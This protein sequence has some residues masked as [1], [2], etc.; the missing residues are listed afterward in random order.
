[1]TLAACGP[2]EQPPEPTP[3]EPNIGRP[4]ALTNA[5]A[6]ESASFEIEN[7]STLSLAWEISVANDASNPQTG[8]W[9]SVSPKSGTLASGEKDTIT[10]TLKSGL[11]AGDYTSTLTV[12]YPGGTTPFDVSG[13]VEGAAP[14]PTDPGPADPDPTGSFSLSTDPD[15]SQPP[16]LT[17]TPSSGGIATI[18][19]GRQDGFTG[20]VDLSLLGA[21]KGVSGEFSPQSVSGS[22]STLILE[23]GSDV[24]T[25]EYELTVKGSSSDLSASTKVLLSVINGANPETFSLALSPSNLSVAQGSSKTTELTVKRSGGFDDAVNLSVSGGKPSGVTVTVTPNPVNDT[26]SV[27]VAVGKNTS[28]GSYELTLEGKGG[29][30][31]TATKLG[32]TVLKTDAANGKITGT[33]TTDNFLGDFTVPSSFT[34]GG[35]LLAQSRPDYVEGQ[36]LIDYEPSALSALR[37]DGS[38]TDLGQD[39]AAQYGFELLQSSADDGPTLVRLPAGKSVLEA[40]AE[41]S[42]DSRVRHAGPNHYVYPLSVPNDALYE[43]Q[44]HMAAGGVPVAWDARDSAANINVAIIDSG[45]DLDHPDLQ[46]VSVKG[47]DFCGRVIEGICNYDANVSPDGSTDTHGTHNL[48]II[49]AKGNSRGVAGVLQGGAKIIPIKVFF[50]Y[51][52]TTEKALIDAVRWSVGLNVTGVPKNQNKAKII[53]LSLGINLGG[54]SPMLEKAIQQAQSAGA[55]VI[56]SAGN[57]GENQIRAPASYDKVIAVGA[58][59]SKFERSCFSNTGPELDIMAPGGDGYLCDG[60]KESILST[61]PGNDYGTLIGTSQAAPLVTGVAALIWSQ[62][63]GLNASQ[64]TTKLLD[65]AYKSSSMTTNGYGAGIVRA[66][67]AFDFPKPGST[68]SVSASGPSSQLDTVKL[69]VDG[70]SERFSL[71]GLK[72]GE[73]T[74]EADVGKLSVSE[75]VTLKEGETL[76]KD[77]RLEP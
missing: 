59:N 63:P 38:V 56:A 47:Y 40:A 60:P 29:G 68:I 31:T 6:Q 18:L 53:N 34:G 3:S 69:G 46:G 5:E 54:E 45:Y 24:A 48:G 76:D 73:Y 65:S 25:G 42:G 75:T 9:F 15:Y 71:E 21:P 14:G 64:V 74:L 32:L 30:K 43:Q 11:T 57:D 35:N 1:M 44:W 20:E 16:A 22:S 8:D 27:K 12:T 67:V 52:R 26:A 72:A 61:L 2:K 62:S 50:N 55:L 4:E 37:A 28:V 10:L 49:A 7:T 17:V 39:L 77:L 70:A 66:D 36:L 19:V 33:V 51:S 58:V 41:L 13:T 23:T